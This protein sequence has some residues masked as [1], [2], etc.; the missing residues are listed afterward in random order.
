MQKYQQVLSG[1]EGVRDSGGSMDAADRARAH[2]WQ[3][4]LQRDRARVAGHLALAAGVASSGPGRRRG[5]RAATRCD[6]EGSGVSPLGSR[7][8]AQ[9]RHRVAWR[10][11]RPVGLRRAAARGVGRGTV[12]LEDPPANQPRA[13]AREANGG[14][15][16]LHGSS[17]AT[18]VVAARASRGFGL[19][20]S[21]RVRFRSHRPCGSG[22]LLSCLAGTD[23]VRR[24][25]SL[26]LGGG[27]RASRSCEP[28]AAV[29][30]V[31]PDGGFRSR[32][33]IS[34]HA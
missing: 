5:D 28:A 18:G 13:A 8:R 1:R 19:C 27:R 9:D 2:P 14:R 31:E 16:R 34:S 33:I 3:S 29:V 25:H 15:V 11:G 32:S 7:A 21:P 30:H 20:D 6:S 26:S 4:S 23:R 12:D 17:R 24:R 10:V 22:A